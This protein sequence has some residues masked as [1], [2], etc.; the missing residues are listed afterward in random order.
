MTLD[1]IPLTPDPYKGGGFIYF[2]ETHQEGSSCVGL[3]LSYTPTQV[4]T[5]QQHITFNADGAQLRNSNLHDLV[6]VLLHV[7]E[8]RRKED[9]NLTSV[10]RS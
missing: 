2:S 4:D 9:A 3:G 5:V 7:L 6:T 10:E 1:I 8:W